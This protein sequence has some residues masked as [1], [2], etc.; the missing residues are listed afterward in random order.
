MPFI[1]TDKKYRLKDGKLSDI[2]PTVL[3]IMNID[4]PSDMTGDNLIVSE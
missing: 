1:I 2:A 3:S 4:I